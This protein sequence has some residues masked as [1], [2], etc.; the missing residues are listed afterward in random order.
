MD[1][2]VT[3][4]SFNQVRSSRETSSWGLCVWEESSHQKKSVH[5]IILKDRSALGCGFT[6]FLTSLHTLFTNYRRKKLYNWNYTE[7]I[8]NLKS[9]WKKLFALWKEVMISRNIRVKKKKRILGLWCASVYGY[10]RT[11][12]TSHPYRADA[13]PDLSVPNLR[14]WPTLFV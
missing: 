13:N 12:V 3:K 6:C 10:Q 4:S 14:L 7:R 1:Q 5:F 11:V 9:K 2:L 8:C